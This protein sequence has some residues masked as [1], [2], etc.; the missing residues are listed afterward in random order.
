MV[1]SS[2]DIRG[3]I[4]RR[5]LLVDP[6]DLSLIRPAS[7]CLRLG[8]RC[9]LPYYSRTVDV[10]D[11]ETYPKYEEVL[12]PPGGW[13][14]IPAKKVVLLSTYEKISLSRR[15]A[16]WLGNLS[17]L[18]RLGL[19]VVFSN[20]VSPGYGEQ[21]PSAC[22]LEVFNSTDVSIRL[23]PQMRICHL[24]ILRLASPASDAYDSQV[25]TYSQQSGP[26]GSVFFEDFEP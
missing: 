25:G 11:R 3:L 9:P 20:Y 10:A 4:E 1:C 16:G 19:Q 21:G 6:L 8:H 2:N 24:V 14:E 23:R 18:A 12:A 13:L 7:L 15:L 5:E 17:G 26:K 22:T